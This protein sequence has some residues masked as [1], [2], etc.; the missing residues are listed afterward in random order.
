[1]S[2]EIK[3]VPLDFAWPLKETWAG[4]AERRPCHACKACGNVSECKTCDG[5]MTEPVRTEPPEGSGYQ[6]WSVM[7]EGSP[8]SPVFEERED[9][10]KW[11]VEHATFWAH[12]K[13][14]LE[15]WRKVAEGRTYMIN[16][17]TGTLEW[18]PV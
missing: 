6:L 17:R 12:F 14:T 4:Y 18:L 16:L 1:M 13:G 3:R 8:A 11:C 10:L 7:G 5:E 9:L 2:R 15:D